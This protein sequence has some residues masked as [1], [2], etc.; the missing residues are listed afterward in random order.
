M[1]RPLLTSGFPPA[2]K[3]NQDR[4]NTSPGNDTGTTCLL[5]G[6]FCVSA[7]FE[8]WCASTKAEFQHETTCGV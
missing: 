5:Q 2:F 6:Q 4:H 1:K 8:V 7:E 3:L